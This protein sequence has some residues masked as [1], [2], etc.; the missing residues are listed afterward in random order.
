[1]LQEEKNYGE[2]LLERDREREREFIILS[3]ILLKSNNH[4]QF[5]ELFLYRC[6]KLHF[7]KQNAKDILWVQKVILT[8][9][10]NANVNSNA[11][12]KED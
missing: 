9:S 10:S 1:M 8:S 7:G 6:T 4:C 12:F 11:A 5:N 3:V 2:M